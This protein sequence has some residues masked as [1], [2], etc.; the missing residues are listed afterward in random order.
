[1]LF[2]DIPNRLSFFFMTGPS[3]LDMEDQISSGITYLYTILVFR[4]A[5]VFETVVNK[6]ITL[7]CHM[8]ASTKS[9][10]DFE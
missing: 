2:L 5:T 10:N 3:R 4:I 1:M 9:W 7:L 6:T 8:S